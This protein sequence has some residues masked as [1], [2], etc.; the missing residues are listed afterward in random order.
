MTRHKAYFNQTEQLS[1]YE[2]KDGGLLIHDV[3][4]M[5]AG[6]WTLSLTLYLKASEEPSQSW[7]TALGLRR[8]A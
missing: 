2:E 1:S 6:S 7:P 4:I 5:A 3:I 8:A